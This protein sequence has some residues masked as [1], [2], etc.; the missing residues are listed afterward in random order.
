VLPEPAPPAAE[1]QIGLADLG[2]LDFAKGAGL[3]PAIVQHA[4]NGAILML[5]Y[6]SREALAATLT[7]G[8]VVLFS[9][10]RQRLWEKGEA[11]GHSLELACVRTD[12]DRD[13]LLIAAWP[14]GPTCH[15]GTVSCF[16]DAPAAA[17]PQDFLAEL[18][19]VIAARIAERPAGSYTAR[20][21][22]QGTRRVAQK[23]GEEGL[24]LALA[25]AGGA[26]EE[27]IAEG[28]DLLYHLLVLLKVRGLSLERVV[29]EL[30]ARHAARG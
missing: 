28:A 12:C 10:S 17:A 13:A 23:L 18:G 2:T 29:A 26:D 16:G 8:R 3:L 27:V 7:R 5:G 4:G 24:E 11:S 14:H 21:A 9:R 22:A 30:R 19:A 6:M 15:R 20:L 1:T 25:G